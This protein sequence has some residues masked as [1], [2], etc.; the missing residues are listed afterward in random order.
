VRAH[1]LLDD[2]WA[3]AR[4]ALLRRR[5]WIAVRA[6]AV[7]SVLQPRAPRRLLARLGRLRGRPR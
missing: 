3:L 4:E 1:D 7:A 2:Q 5:P 6:L